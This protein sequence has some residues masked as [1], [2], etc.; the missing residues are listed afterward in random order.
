MAHRPAAPA[1]QSR[2]FS[3]PLPPSAL[4]PPPSS[5]PLA[6]GP[7]ACIVTCFGPWSYP[8]R[9]V[10]PVPRH[11]ANRHFRRHGLYRPGIDENPPPPPQCGDGRR[12]QPP[13][14]PAAGGHDPPLAARPAGPAS[15]G[16]HRRRSG[17]TRRV[18]LQL[19]PPRGQRHGHPAVAGRR[20]PRGGFLGRLPPQRRRGLCPMVRAEAPRSRP[21]GQGGL[22]AAGVVPP[23]DR[24][25]RPGGQSRLLPHVGHLAAGPAVEGRGDRGRRGSSS[26]RR[27]ASPAPGGRPS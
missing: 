27:A 19:P 12:H 11:D 14:R 7:G 23:G 26:I 8:Q 22:R 6:S 21:A 2:G 5:A 16:P 13:G 1:T 18:R 17:G 9:P 24:A 20:C 15:G 3:G 10:R 4:R 25:R